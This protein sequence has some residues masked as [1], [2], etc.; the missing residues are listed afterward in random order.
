MPVAKMGLEDYLSRYPN[1]KAKTISAYEE[2]IIVAKQDL[3]S[4]SVYFLRLQ[5]SQSAKN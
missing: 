1:Q 2:K 4:A 3:I 5:L